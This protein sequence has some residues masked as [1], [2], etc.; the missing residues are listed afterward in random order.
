MYIEIKKSLHVTCGNGTLEADV[1]VVAV[2]L[3]IMH[4]AQGRNTLSDS[5]QGLAK[6]LKSD[7]SHIQGIHTPHL[8]CIQF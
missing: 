3:F 5:L 1:S 8:I 7:V 6:V 4:Q 2:P